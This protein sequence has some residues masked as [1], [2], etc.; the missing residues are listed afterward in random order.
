MA[1]RWGLTIPSFFFREKYKP[2]N[3]K[4]I[5]KWKGVFIMGIEEIY[6]YLIDYTISCEESEEES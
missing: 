6:A 3:E 2:H 1:L 4:L 5:T